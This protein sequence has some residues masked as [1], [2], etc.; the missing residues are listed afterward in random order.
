[1]ISD[2]DNYQTQPF[3]ACLVWQGLAVVS[4]VALSGDYDSHR[5]TEEYK[6]PFGLR[7][8]CPSDVAVPADVR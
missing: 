8:P 5:E 2:I 6:K 4:L 7:L 3:E 1:M